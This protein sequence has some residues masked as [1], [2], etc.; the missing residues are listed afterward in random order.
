MVVDGPP[1]VDDVAACS[2]LASENSGLSDE[3]ATIRAI[4]LRLSM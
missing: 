2:G 4:R 3:K 1:L